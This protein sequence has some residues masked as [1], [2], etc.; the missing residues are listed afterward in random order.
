MSCPRKS[1]NRKLCVIREKDFTSMLNFILPQRLSR[2][3]QHDSMHSHTKRLRYTFPPFKSLWQKIRTTNLWLWTDF[4]LMTQVF[5][6]ET[7][8][9]FFINF[10]VEN[11]L[12]SHSGIWSR[13]NEEKKTAIRVQRNISIVWK[14]DKKIWRDVRIT[15]KRTNIERSNTSSMIYTHPSNC[16]RLIIEL[17]MSN[18]RKLEKSH[19]VI[20][21]LLTRTIYDKNDWL[22]SIFWS[23]RNEMRKKNRIDFLSSLIFI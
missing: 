10:D 15:N 3:N 17:Q 13:R 6:K 23:K 20:F 11:G 4:N 12:W 1:M 16:Q 9:T 19:R 18:E 7:G 5:S 21:G 14:I 22:I 2:R 8:E